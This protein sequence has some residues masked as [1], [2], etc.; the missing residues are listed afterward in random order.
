M[1]VE[2]ALGEPIYEYIDWVGGTSTG[3]LIA[4]GLSIGNIVWSFNYF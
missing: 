4:A 1:E 2:K 3:A